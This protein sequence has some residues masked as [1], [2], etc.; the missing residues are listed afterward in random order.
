MT[1]HPDEVNLV[2]LGKRI[3]LFPKIG[4]LKLIPS[5]SPAGGT[6]GLYPAEKKGVNYIFRI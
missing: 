5:T 3:K 4:V 6:P 2:N 1:L